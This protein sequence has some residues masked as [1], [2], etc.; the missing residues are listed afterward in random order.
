MHGLWLI[1]HMGA[2]EP[3][4]PLEMRVTGGTAGEPVTIARG[5]G[6][7]AGRCLDVAGG[8]CLDIT[9]SARLGAAVFDDSGVATLRLDAP[10][11]LEPGA[12][13][14]FQA[15]VVRGEAGV[16][17]MATGALAR[18]V[19]EPPGASLSELGPGDLVITEIMQN[20]LAVAD[21]Q[22][23]WFE[24]HN[25][26]ATPVDLSG[27]VIRDDGGEA[28]TL[29]GPLVVTPGGLALL[30]TGADPGQNGGL[31]PDHIYPYA[32]LNLSNGTDELELVFEDT[33]FDR[34]AWDDGVLFPD[35]EGA[36][37][38]LH[39]GSWCE[40][41]SPFGDGDSGSPG[42]TNPPCHMLD[43]WYLDADFDG[44]GDPMEQVFAELAPWG[45]VANPDDCDDSEHHVHPGAPELCDGQQND[46]DLP[47]TDAEE[48]G[49]VAFVDPGG[50]WRDESA[51]FAAGD[52]HHYT[53]SEPGELRF[54]RG[55]FHTWIETGGH[56]VSVVGAYGADHTTLDA[57]DA[58]RL[59][60]APSGSLTVRGLTLRDGFGWYGPSVRVEYGSLLLEHSVVTGSRALEDG[61]GVYLFA[62]TG[63][64][65]DTV[66]EGNEAERGGGI[67]SSES[68]LV[69][70]D[71]LVVGNQAEYGGG[72]YVRGDS[73]LSCTGSV[74]LD[75]G[76][77]SNTAVWEG[78]G[79]RVEGTGPALALTTCDFG[80]DPER[81]NTPFDL[82]FDT[83]S[84]DLADETTLAC[85]DGLCF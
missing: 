8:L 17:S 44:F 79:L 15:V 73:D 74:G 75:A 25:T 76:F 83:V 20:P 37:M 45:Y 52:L 42:E 32:S 19:G 51:A 70:T 49:L 69:L 1:L 59:V 3:G 35:P 56:D 58:E 21:A 84:Y 40:A 66:I 38:Q 16:D 48:D 82:A 23:E 60:W 71:T 24:I 46:C 31:V 78:G 65:H 30:A 5:N 39:E 67:Y 27:L 14:A 54:C 13:A 55:T 18:T 2:L 64:I 77:L 63:T 85:S 34:V 80:D 28:I 61:G 22:G 26:T 10:S 29:P 72:A 68:S 33:T 36:S 47:W 57:D 53:F 41:T 50:S 12:P 11:W 81:N 7:G 4:A 6:L 9:G 62:S 43:R